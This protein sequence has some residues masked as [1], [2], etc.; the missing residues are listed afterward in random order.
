MIIPN[1]EECAR[2]FREQGVPERVLRHSR[3]VEGVALA[4][5]RRML[6]GDVD[7]ELLSAACRLH[8]LDKIRTLS[9]YESHGR[10]AGDILETRGYRE[11]AEV[12]RAHRP[13]LIASEPFVWEKRLLKYADL[14]ALGSRVVS[15][16]ERIE[17]LKV[18]YPFMFRKWPGITERAYS[19][20]REIY[21]K[22]GVAVGELDSSVLLQEESS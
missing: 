21:D 4:L 17:D 12:V 1:E 11:V 8:D 5:G 2:L 14:R 3:A 10:V 19:L 18:R 16:T 15:L 22:I 7:L 20:E 6:E 9:D 13:E